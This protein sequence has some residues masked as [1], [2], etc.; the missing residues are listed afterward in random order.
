MISQDKHGEALEDTTVL[1]EFFELQNI[2]ILS[3]NSCKLRTFYILKSS[4]LII[5]NLRNREFSDKHKP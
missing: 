2:R 3:K 1:R 4:E 5:L